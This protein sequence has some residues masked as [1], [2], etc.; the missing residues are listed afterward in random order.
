MNDT[1][2]FSYFHFLSKLLNKRKEKREN[3]G[4]CV[5]QCRKFLLSQ[6]L[7]H[8]LVYKNIK[9]ITKCEW[10]TLIFDERIF[11]LLFKN[12]N[13]EMMMSFFFCFVKRFTQH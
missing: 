11:F 7:R 1:K 12:K 13:M 8:F 6:F 9:I 5:S 3:I 2:S 10:D 4:M